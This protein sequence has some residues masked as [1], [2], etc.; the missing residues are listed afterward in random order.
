MAVEAEW[1][2]VEGGTRRS[3]SV[4]SAVACALCACGKPEAAAASLRDMLELYAEAYN[5]SG[6][7]GRRIPPGSERL[8]LD[9]PKGAVQRPEAGPLDHLEQLRGGDASRRGLPLVDGVLD[10]PRDAD[11]AAA[12]ACHQVIHA[13][14]RAGAPELAYQTVLAMHKVLCCCC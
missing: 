14:E 5:S 9:P 2:R 13:C 3:L 7:S 8:P 4:R 12:Q 10:A 11:R 6:G 1:Q